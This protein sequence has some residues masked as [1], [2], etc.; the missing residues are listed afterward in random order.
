MR[1]YQ[2]EVIHQSHDQLGGIEVVE[3]S[4]N[5][6]LHFGTDA[7]QS[8]MLLRDPYQLSLSYTRAMC[9]ALL[10]CEEP[11]RVLLLGLGG[12]SLAKFLLHHFPQCHIDAV[13]FRPE[14]HRVAQQHF[15]LPE[16]PRLQV[17]YDDAGHFVRR[18]NSAEGDYDLML[19]D[20]FLD[21]GI[22][23]SVCGMS[24]FDACREQLSP[25]GVLSMNLW[26]DDRVHSSDFIEDMGLSFNNQVLRL[27]VEGKANVIG[28]AT[29]QAAVK[30]QLRAL[31]ETAKRLEQR[32]TI[33]F[34]ALLHTLRKL[35][36]SFF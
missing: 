6:S 18:H 11:R 3:D 14:V 31:D 30:K 9:A 36:R 21:H 4:L 10:F 32:T 34:T 35:H 8:S 24:F 13:E 23:Y 29:R 27:P 5:R 26:S 28:I 25:D 22:A 17:V 16:E 1:K 12:G 2:G 7:R 15:A 33:E 20:A 19:V